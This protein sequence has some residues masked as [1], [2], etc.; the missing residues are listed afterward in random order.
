MS[1]PNIHKALEIFTQNIDALV[2][3]IPLLMALTEVTLKETRTDFEEYLEANGEKIHEGDDSIFYEL[4]SEYDRVASRKK[5]NLDG[6]EE[7]LQILPRIFVVSFVSE[8]DAFLGN[9]LKEFYSAKPEMLN[10]SERQLKFSE[11]SKFSSIDEARDFVLEKEIESILRQSHAEQFSILESKFDLQL[12]KGLDIWKDFIE[13]T[14]RRNLYVHTS[15]IVSSQYQ[16][17]C[18]N[19]GI[20]LNES[21][22]VGKYLPIDKQYL[23]NSYKHIYE[24]GFKLANVLWRKA[25]PEDIE[26]ADNS[27]I[28]ITY[29]I[30]IQE[31]YEMAKKLLD[32]SL[33]TLKKHSNEASRKI[34][35][36]N[37]AIAYK[38]SQESKEAIKILDSVDWS[39]TG[40]E[41][42]LA[43][44]VLKDQ[45][46]KAI[47]IMK[48]IGSK[49]VIGKVEYKEW[50]LFKDFRLTSDFLDAYKEIF[51]EEFKI[52]EQVKSPSRML[53]EKHIHN[54]NPQKISEVEAVSE[55]AVVTPST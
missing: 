51:E 39:A 13:L 55:D 25:F 9:I 8:Y 29:E 7:T 52:V 20:T 47:S 18:K 36:I 53:I 30:L 10:S 48:K 28:N 6:M 50:P 15:G 26:N 1:R 5:R 43:V 46:S 41:Y 33:L 49:G 11:L 17:V 24:I 38:F 27:L 3:S 31:R 16:K 4:D 35:I 2:D 40:D 12:T 23:I 14:E 34:L 19:H 54:I 21:Q 22:E 32:F 37:R 44:S 45:T 42:Q